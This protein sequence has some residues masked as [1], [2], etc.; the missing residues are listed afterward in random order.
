VH[1]PRG[2]WLESLRQT[3]A[4]NGFTADFAAMD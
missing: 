2:F 4:V 1:D 3:V